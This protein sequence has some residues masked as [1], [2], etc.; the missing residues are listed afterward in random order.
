MTIINHQR[1]ISQAVIQSSNFCDVNSIRNS[2]ILHNS[3]LKA[4]AD[5]KINM[6]KKLKFS[7]GRVENNV[8]NEE[9]AGYQHFLLFP[10]Y[11]Q[12]TFYTGLLKVHIVRQRF[13][14]FMLQTALHA[15]D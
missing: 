15:T 11:F 6:A 1:E 4:F 9:N 8:A 3:I 14:S 12:K 5:N 2:K 7:F 13:K 10:Q